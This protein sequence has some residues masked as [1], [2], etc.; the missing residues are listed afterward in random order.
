[1]ASGWQLQFP[2]IAEEIEALRILVRDT[3]SSLL[4]FALYRSSGDR[5][6]AI[7]ALKERLALPVVEFTLSK[8]ESDP[9]IFLRTL[10]AQRRVCIFFYNIEEALPDVAGY[11]NLQR[12][13]FA[14][15]PH[16]IIFWVNE[17]GLREIATHAPDFWAWRSGVFDFRIEYLKLQSVFQAELVESIPFENRDDLEKRIRLYEE[18]LEDYSSQQ[19]PDER[20]L[21]GLQIKLGSAYHLLGRFELAEKHSRA[22]LQRSRRIKDQHLEAAALLVLGVLA[23]EQGRLDEAEKNA[24]QSLTLAKQINDDSLIASSCHQLGNL[25]YVGRRFE[26]AEIW[27]HQSLAITESKGIERGAAMAYRALGNIAL[28]RRKFDEAERWYRKSLVIQERLGLARET[29]IDYHQLGNLA[30]LQQRFAEAKA[31]YQKA[32]EI[33]K[34]LGLERELALELYQLGR[35]AEEQQQWQQAREHLLKALE[36]F[37][38]FHDEHNRKIVLRNLARLWQSTGDTS[39]FDAVAAILKIQPQE[40]EALLQKALQASN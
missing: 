9:F 4:A 17:H 6:A 8:P 24:R 19:K 28:A 16:A 18:L 15:H 23:Q 35:V 13:E 20:F 29:A 30:F 39:L 31:W 36:I 2:E 1:M 11:V 33:K 34:R 10:S 3:N 32:R 22:V 14:K 12:E 26:E 7:Y 5:A 40:V 25:A 27:Y 38:E 21:A 37:V